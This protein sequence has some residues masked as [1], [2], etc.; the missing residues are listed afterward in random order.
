MSKE[1][2]A[3]LP[4]SY[5]KEEGGAWASWEGGWL[6]A[7]YLKVPYMLENWPGIYSL[8]FD[9]PAIGYGRFPRWDK[10]NGWTHTFEYIKALGLKVPYFRVVYKEG[11][12]GI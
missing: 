5:A 11:I 10:V 7:D 8:A 6:E 2:K 3:V 9:D 4:H 12:D 1:Y